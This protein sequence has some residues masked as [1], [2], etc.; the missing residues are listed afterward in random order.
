[1]TDHVGTAELGQGPRDTRRIQG[2]KYSHTERGKATFWKKRF[3]GLERKS[4]RIGPGLSL[5]FALRV[6]FFFLSFD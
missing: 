3:P 4:I 5:R 2:E 6:E 1:L